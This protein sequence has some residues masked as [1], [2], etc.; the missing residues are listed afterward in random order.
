MEEIGKNESIRVL[1]DKGAV[2]AEG[3]I[4]LAGGPLLD[5]AILRVE[6]NGPLVIDLTAVEFIDSSGLRSLLTA[7]RRAESRES[8]VILR[9]PSASVKRLLSITGT[10]EQFQ[11]ESDDASSEVAADGSDR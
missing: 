4:D 5:T 1:I 2:V 3:D 9:N 11:I 6:G 7:S 10:A 8:F